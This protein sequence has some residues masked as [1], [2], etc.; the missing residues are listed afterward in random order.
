MAPVTAETLGNPPYLSTGDNGTGRQSAGFET[1]PVDRSG[2]STSA[3]GK[4]SGRMGTGTAQLGPE[5]FTNVCYRN[6]YLTR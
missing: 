4:G 3:T 1:A 2:S 6:C 5:R